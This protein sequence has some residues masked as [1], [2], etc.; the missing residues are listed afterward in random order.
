MAEQ[1][2]YITKKQ[3]SGSACFRL[4]METTTQTNWDAQDAAM[5]ALYEG[6]LANFI[7]GSINRPD[8][9]FTTEM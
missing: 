7:E 8:H 4:H 5:E 9:S 3:R 1:I 6:T 2:P